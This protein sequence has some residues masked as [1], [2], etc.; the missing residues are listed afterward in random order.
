MSIGNPSEGL[1]YSPPVLGP[2]T[3]RVGEG[4][5]HC[6][7]LSGNWRCGLTYTSNIGIRADLLKASD[8]FGAY[9]SVDVYGDGDSPRGTVVDEVIWRRSD[10]SPVEVR[11]V[12]QEVSVDAVSSAGRGEG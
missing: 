4:R 3:L 12:S 5:I 11:P 1:S 10:C 6:A 9:A 2:L 8:G 7:L